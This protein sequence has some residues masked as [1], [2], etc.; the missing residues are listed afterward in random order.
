MR[1]PQRIDDI[2]TR[3]DDGTVSFDTSRLE[4]RLDSLMRIGRRAVAAVLFAGMLVGGALL[5][6]PNSVLGT[7]L[8]AVSG[9]PLLY[10]VFG[11]LGRR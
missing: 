5:L 2:I 9:A 3:I 8:I 4:R 6:A 1:L 11:G 10:A 7:V